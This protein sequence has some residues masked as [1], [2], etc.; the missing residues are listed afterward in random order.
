MLND[1]GFGSCR[2][3]YSRRDGLA[4]KNWGRGDGGGEPLPLQKKRTEN[5]G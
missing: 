1:V 3:K 4:Q 5:G 2:T